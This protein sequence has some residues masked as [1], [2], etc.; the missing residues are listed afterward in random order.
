MRTGTNGN[1]ITKAPVVQIV[2][3]LLIFFSV[4][5][6]FIALVASRSQELQILF[7]DRIDFIFAR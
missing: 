4:G 5:G 6:N 3:A 1:V 7:K 2:F